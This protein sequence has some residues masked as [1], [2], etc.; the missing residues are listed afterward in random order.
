MKET[1]F[2]YPYVFHT[3]ITAF[4]CAELTCYFN[5]NV[6]SHITDW[7]F[8]STVC[9]LVMDCWPFSGGVWYLTTKL[10][11]WW[12]FLLFSKTAFPCLAFWGQHVRTEDTEQVFP[13][14]RVQSDWKHMV[15]HITHH[16]FT[17]TYLVRIMWQYQDIRVNVFFF[18]GKIEATY[19]SLLQETSLYCSVS[20]SSV[21]PFTTVKALFITWMGCRMNEMLQ[22]QT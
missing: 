13:A 8:V 11:T 19:I 9:H 1:T 5:I 10:A 16:T 12:L 4:F 2:F 22:I 15:G 6:H 7:L 21:S 18:S 3:Y 20:E 17:M 14:L